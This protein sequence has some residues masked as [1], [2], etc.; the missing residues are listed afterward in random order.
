MG[1]ITARS[2]VLL[3]EF[4]LLAAACSIAL[5]A[6]GCNES[7]ATNGKKRIVLLINTPS[8][9]W[10]TGRKGMELAAKDL[11]LA[12]AGY[13]AVF[14]T[15]DQKEQ[16]Q[17]DVLRQLSTQHDIVGIA[18]S[19]VKADNLAIVEEMRK[20]R[21]KGVHVICMDGD[22]DRAKYRDAREAYIGTDN[23]RAGEVLGDA[24]KHLLD[25]RKAAKGGYVDFVGFR[26]AQNAI[27]RMDGIKKTL[28]GS[29]PELDRMEDGTDLSVAKGNVR[30][31]FEN[32]PDLQA[33]V[34][35]WS[36]NAPLI[37]DVVGREHADRR[38]SL[39]V[40]T[41]DCEAGAIEQMGK[42]NIDVMVVQNP[43]DICYQSVRL[44]EALAKDDTATVKKMLPDQGK[45]GGDIYNT[46]IRV[47]VPNDKSPL[48]ANLFSQYGPT[49]QFFTLPKF[50]DWLNERGLTGS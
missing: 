43:Y 12:D 9:Y 40:A 41:F 45:E 17:I 14:A 24:A 32:H 42:G 3:P 26:T 50:K 19:P 6:G 33:L 39:T 29:Y 15:N 23:F 28:G 10:E 38:S 37:G 46:D 5:I 18:I 47:V 25:D 1:R 48:T 2:I 7:P 36:Y 16:G 8:S 27:D 20:L 44:L 31:A 11:K 49:V 34:G 22:V 21:K 35:I 4:L 13:E 30:K